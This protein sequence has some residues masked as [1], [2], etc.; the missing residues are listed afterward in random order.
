M[1]VEDETQRNFLFG[2]NGLE[3]VFENRKVNLIKE[4]F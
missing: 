2:L 4:V 3:P 1:L